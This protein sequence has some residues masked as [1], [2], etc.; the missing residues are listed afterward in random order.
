MMEDENQSASQLEP[1][2]LQSGGETDWTILE[3]MSGMAA[4][5][6]Q[7]VVVALH[8]EREQQ[9]GL[10]L[11]AEHGYGG[12]VG[13]RTAATCCCP[14]LTMAQTLLDG[15]LCHSMPCG[16]LSILRA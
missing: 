13:L 15:F 2:L 7:D 9:H 8:A 4:D 5:P 10:N 11:L 16:T 14:Q 1:L 6:P 12:L 3:L